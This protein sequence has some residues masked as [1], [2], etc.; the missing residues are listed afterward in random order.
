MKNGNNE[1]IIDG[2]L[3]KYLFLDINIEYYFLKF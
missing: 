1:N 3:K 2:E